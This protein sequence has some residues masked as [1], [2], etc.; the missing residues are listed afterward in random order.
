MKVWINAKQVEVDGEQTIL[1]VL[2]KNSIDVPT[3]CHME[4]RL[5]SGACRIC[6]VE[7]EGQQNLIPSCST[8]IQDGMKIWTSNPR[9]IN[10]RKTIIE[11]L[12]SSHPDDCLYCDKQD[13]CYLLQLARKYAVDS[14]RFPKTVRDLKPDYAS[15]SI[16]RDPSKCILCGKCVRVCE[17]VQGVGCIDFVGRGFSTAIGC[18]F[19]S[20]I[21]VTSCVNCG[22]CVAVCPT[23]ALMETRNI[24]DVMNAIRSGKYVVAQHAP[25]VSVSLGEEFS[26]P[27]GRDVAGLMV[28]ALKM[29]GFKAVF[30]TSFAADLTI[31]E[32]ASELV[33]R[34][35]KKKTLPLF[36]SCCPAWVKYVETFYPDFIDNLSTCKSPHQ[37]LG[38]VIKSYYA[39]KNNIDPDDIVVVSIMPCTA[40]KFEVKRPELKGE[41]SSDVDYSLTT[42]ELARMISM[43]GID[44]KKL[45]PSEADMP[46]GK[47]SGAGK[48]FGASGGVSEAAIRTA[49]F[50]LTGNEISNLD[51]K[52]VRG[53]D[54]VK[55]A[56]IHI[57]GIK[58]RI[59]VVNGL[60]NFKKLLET[61]DLKNDFDFIEVMACP[62]G[63]INGGGQPFAPDRKALSERMNALYSIDS[64]EKVR[65]SHTNPAILELYKDFLIKPNSEKSHSLLHTHYSKRNVEDR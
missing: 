20:S 7:V 37:M 28:T 24:A 42:R 25:A 13:K 43:N 48:I 10:A 2:K 15:P 17:E 32:E 61:S 56:E 46:F 29:M 40:K 33:D 6:V 16:S 62:G 45:S 1:D 47:R 9:V 51:F 3:L 18:A 65:T 35:T 19:N 34:I 14:N 26:L 39:E 54:G 53:L 64:S 52:A 59:A 44:L 50:L 55:K 41:N 38:E 11:L 63:C 5:P 36:T 30:D 49:H 57:E 21:N 23:G 27:Y 60:G 8:P 12:L 58:L 31:M 4:G 22:Q